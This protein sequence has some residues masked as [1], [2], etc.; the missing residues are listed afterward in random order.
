[1]KTP[2]YTT[3]DLGRAGKAWLSS[4]LYLIWEVFT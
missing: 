4:L 1:M 2:H 3:E